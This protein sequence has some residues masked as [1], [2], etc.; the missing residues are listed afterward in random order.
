[1]RLKTHI[2]ALSLVASTLFASAQEKW[3]YDFIVPDNGNFVT[4][5]KRAN[6]RP[7]KSKRFRI[8]VKEGN[9]R[10]HGDGAPATVVENGRT[11]SFSRTVTT[12]KASNTSIAGEGSGCTQ[13][14]SCP[15]HEGLQVTPTLQIEGADSTYIQDLEL[16]SNFRNDLNAVSQY[17][18]AL[19]EKNCRGTILKGVSLLSYRG[20]YHGNDGGT[21]YLEDCRIKGS[22]E[23]LLGG[24]TVYLNRCDLGLRKHPGRQSVVCAPSTEAGRAYGYVFNDC[25][26]GGEAS[27]DSFYLLA[28]PGGRSPKALFVN[29]VMQ[30]I[31]KAEGY[32]DGKGAI[33]SRFAEYNSMDGLF[34]LID[35]SARRTTYTDAQGTP[36]PMASP[37]TMT[38][39]EAERCTP[40]DVFPA[41]NVEEKT[42]MVAPPHLRISGRALVWED[43]PEAGCYAICRDRKVVAFT[44]GT[45]YTIPKGTYEGA[46]FSIRCANAMGGLGDRSN[47][48]V[49]PQ[50]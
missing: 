34:G 17:S 33:P 31:P 49:Y 43:V 7:D 1:M 16:W 23:L 8:F 12:L 48:V 24:G 11:V 5:V 35:T 46:C 41:W 47:E 2:M 29:T 13:V 20:S 50:R 25:T 30:L 26:V 36:R 9:Y 21:T 18:V 42:A 38:G 39:E 19:G 40:A 3:K 15:Q 27:Q 32:G 10:I 37:A 22:S 14:E 6:E 44:D 28:I 45:T 4:A